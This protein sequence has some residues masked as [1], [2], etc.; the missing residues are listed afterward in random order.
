MLLALERLPTLPPGPHGR[1]GRL[2]GSTMRPVLGEVLTAVVTPFREDGSVDLDAFKRLCRTSSTTAPTGVVVA[3]TT[4][5]APTLTDE[6]RLA[7]FAAAVERSAT[8][9]PS[10]RAP[11]PTRRPTRST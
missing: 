7:L 8:A 11:A 6:E 3:G 9:P 5:E 4:G 10:S 2:A 1:A